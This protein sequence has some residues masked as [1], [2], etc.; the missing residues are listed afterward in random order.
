MLIAQRRSGDHL[1]G[2]WEFPGGKRQAGETPQDCLQRELREELGIEVEVQDLVAEIEHAYP[3]RRVRLQFFQCQWR[4]REPQALDCQA[5][6]WVT[7]D[8]IG[9]FSF[10]PAD[11]QILQRLLTDSTFCW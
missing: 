8:Q 10:P 9:N 11:A 2:Y 5:F 3:H 1:A 6:A 4:S 7:R